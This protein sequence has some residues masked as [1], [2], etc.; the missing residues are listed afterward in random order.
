LDVQIKFDLMG[1]FGKTVMRYRIAMAA[2]PLAIV[3]LCLKRQFSEYNTGGISCH[4]CSNSRL[5][6]QF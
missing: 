3:A 1:S 2:F 4:V 6:R 5:L